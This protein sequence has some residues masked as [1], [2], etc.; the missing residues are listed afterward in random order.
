MAEVELDRNVR[1]GELELC[2]NGI[3]VLRGVH[4]V[5]HSWGSLHPL[6]VSRS[7]D[8]IQ[9]KAAKIDTAVY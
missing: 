6:N 3:I 5:G 7:D 2:R 4:T 9:G 1:E 8:T